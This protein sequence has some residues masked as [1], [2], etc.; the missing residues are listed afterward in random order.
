MNVA[1]VQFVV[2]WQTSQVVGKPTVECTG[3]FV[4]LWGGL[5]FPGLC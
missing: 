3:L 4:L 2:L 5:L 1:L